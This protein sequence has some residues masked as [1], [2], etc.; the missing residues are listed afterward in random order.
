MECFEKGLL[1]P[2]DTGGLELRFGNGEALLA[3]LER[4]AHR[5]ALGTLLAEGSRRASAELGHG[6]EAWAMH[7]K[8]LEMPG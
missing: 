7:V 6:S 1:T 2:G 5:D 8:G 3:V 4:I